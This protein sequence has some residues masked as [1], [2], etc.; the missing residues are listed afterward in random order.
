[1]KDAHASNSA[2]AISVTPDFDP[3]DPGTSEGAWV[4]PLSR[5]REW[6][7]RSG[8]LVVVSPHPDDEILG[9]GGLIHSW[10]LRGRTV[11]IVSVTDGEAAYSTWPGLALVRRAELKRALRKLSVTHIAVMRVGLPDGAVADHVNRLRNVVLSLAHPGTTLVAPYEHDGHPDHDAVGRVCCDVASAR[12]VALAR[13]PVWT[14]H[15]AE[16][17][18]L[19]R[20]GLRKFSLTIEARRAKARAIGCFASQLDPPSRAPIVP[21]HV[22]THFQRPFEAF[23]V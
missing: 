22:L 16:P 2:L 17:R 14:W 8:P 18:Q 6:M 5:C 7:P 4:H 21:A 20:A 3:A 15:H 19:A 13:Y 1:M 9:A 23:F 10:A 11:T 12:G